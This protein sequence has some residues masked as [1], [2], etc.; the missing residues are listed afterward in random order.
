M[1]RVFTFQP[2]D[3]H[4]AWA[5]HVG[6]RERVTRKQARAVLLEQPTTVFKNG[7]SYTWKSKHA[8]AGIY[9]IW[10]EPKK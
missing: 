3:G 10:L 9:E 4:W 8:G 7:Y 2:C 1:S 5:D 6:F